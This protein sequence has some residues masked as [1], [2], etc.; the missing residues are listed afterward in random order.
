MSAATVGDLCTI[1][2][3]HTASPLSHDN[4]IRVAIQAAHKLSDIS[5]NSYYTGDHDHS[6]N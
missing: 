2:I 5:V 4:S 3:D 6:F 1:Q